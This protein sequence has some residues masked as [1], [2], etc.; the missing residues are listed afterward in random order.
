MPDAGDILA[1]GHI[2]AEGVGVHTLRSCGKCLACCT[3]SPVPSIEEVHAQAA[4]V[5]QQMNAAFAGKPDASVPDMILD[6]GCPFYT[7]I[8]ARCCRCNNCYKTHCRRKR[9]TGKS[10]R[11][12]FEQ[13]EKDFLEGIAGLK[14]LLGKLDTSDPVPEIRKGL[15]KAE[16]QRLEAD[17]ENGKY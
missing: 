4:D 9:T 2:L 17:K 15:T 14:D 16:Y 5:V 11:A 6:C 3:C 10:I 1:C 13:A 7:G 12:E 8:T